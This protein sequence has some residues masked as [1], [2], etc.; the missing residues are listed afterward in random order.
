MTITCTQHAWTAPDGETF[1]YSQWKSK[2]PAR[3]LIVAVHGLSGAALDYEPLGRHFAAHGITTLALELRG[4]GNDPSEN[5]RGDL[6]HLEDW[7]ADLQAFLAL[8]RGEYTSAPIYYYGESMGAALLT[9]FLAQAPLADQPAGLILASPVV[10]LPRRVTWRQRFLFRFFLWLQPT[11]RI[12]VRKLSKSKK[13]KET[14]YVTRDEAHRQWFETAPHRVDRFT[15]RFFR[16][17]HDL[18]DGCFV[19]APRLRVPVLVIYS[20]QDV[21]ITPARVEEFFGL[22]G[23]SDKEL[24]LF[25][26]A[27]HLLLHDHDKAG[28][29]TRIESWVL[30]RLSSDT[31]PPRG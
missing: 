6:A 28:A 1:S 2:Q 3:A 15:I 20:G 5:R 31:P 22:I 30:S 16:C 8:A 25:P 24:S 9:Q 12:N 29:L 14:R 17:L 23:S 11:F 26:A 4:Q 7:F 10:A 27:Y 21:F 18:I 19:A 13:D